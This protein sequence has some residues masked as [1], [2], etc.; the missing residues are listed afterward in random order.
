MKA[1]SSK[2]LQ[3]LGV[4][5]FVSGCGQIAVP[6]LG[7]VVAESNTQSGQQAQE[8]SALQSPVQASPVTSH[9]DILKQN[10][11]HL[12]TPTGEKLFAAMKQ[13]EQDQALEVN[14]KFFAK[15]AMC[16][17]NASRVLEMIGIKSYSSPLLPA[18]VNAVRKR[19]GLVIQLPKSRAEIAKTVKNLFGGKIPV[20]SFIS[21]CLRADCSGQAGDGHI[22]LVGDIDES[23]Y[24]KIYHNNWYRPDNNPQN[25]WYPYMIPMDWY[26]K[27][28]RR[29]WMA[30]PWIYLHRDSTGAPH[31]IKVRL[32]EIDDLDPTNYFVTL[33]IPV[34]ILNEVRANK[35]VI[36]DGKG[37]V[38]SFAANTNAGAG[39]PTQECKR[40]RV[41]DPSD[42]NG[43]NLRTT[44]S[45]TV[46]CT[47]A[48]GTRVD[49]LGNE[50]LWA[51]VKAECGGVSREG[52][53]FRPFADYD[54]PR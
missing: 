13:W 11:F 15:P 12:I 45:G 16:A 48:N 9:S 41:N 10:R 20:G 31:D 1:N 42:P 35:G 43:V 34:E 28:Y 25:R 6:N 38:Q 17:S 44:P 30:T 21:G 22:A 29:K 36:T 52:Y 37:S 51:K 23:G 27:G 18:M 7:D 24:I 5:A 4:L 8:Q 14:A 50:G 33:S 40:L 32:P 47:L 39:Q 49:L 19:G 3:V 53:V 46:Q 2:L 54:C 26:N